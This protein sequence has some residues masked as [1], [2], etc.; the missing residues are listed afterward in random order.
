MRGLLKDVEKDGIVRWEDV[1]ASKGCPSSLRAEKG[2][3]AVIE[4]LQE[5][6]LSLIHISR[7][8]LK[9][10]ITRMSGWLSRK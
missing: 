8:F 7:F 3:V 2:P 10:M 9:I 4:C 1:A 5:I 6:P